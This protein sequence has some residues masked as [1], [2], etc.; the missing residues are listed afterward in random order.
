MNAY[1]FHTDL[2]DLAFLGTIFIGL[3]FALQLWFTKKINQAANRFLGLALTVIVLEMVH[4]RAIDIPIPLQF[5][6]ALGPLIYFYVLKITRPA[7]KFRRKDLL[8]FIPALAG[9]FV[10]SDPA[11]QLLT[12]ISVVSY[13]YYAHQLIERF[14]RRLKFI[15]GD[16]YRSELRWL[17]KL[18]KGFGLLWLMWIPYIIAWYFYY[19]GSGIQAY[20]CFYLAVAVMLIWIAAEALS[21]A[22]ITVT[23]PALPVTKLPPPA[24]LKQKA[25][26]LK[27]AVELN[28]LYQ[29]PELN[30]NSLAEKLGLSVHELSRIINTALKKN[31]HDFINEY[32][33]RDVARKI[34]DPAYDHI[35]LLG[36]AYDSGFNSK[37][38]FHRIFR[39]MTGKSPSEYKTELRKEGPSYK[40]EPGSR[41]APLVLRHETIPKWSHEKSNRNFMLKSYLTIARRNLSRNKASSLINIGG[42][43]VGIACSL[44]IML[45]VQ[46]EY[47]MDA[48]HPNEAR[49]YT[50]YERVYIGHK[51]SAGYGTA[52]LIADEMKKVVP[53]VQYATQFDWGTQNTFQVGEKIA[54]LDGHFA[55]A[56]YFKV[57][58]NKLLQGN[59]QT[60]LN[61][62]SSI[63]ISRK[64]A[65]QFYGSPEAAIGKSIR[66]ENMKNFVVGAVFEDLPATSSEK[67]DYLVNWYEF[68]QENSWASDWD[69][70]GPRTFFMLRADANPAAVERKLVHFMD[71]YKKNQKAGVFSMTLGMQPYSEVYLHGN[72]T[73]DKLDGG[74]IEYVR[75]FSIIAV[76]I[77]LI[78][79]I[80]FMNLSTA[81][82]LNRAREIG[83]RK[84]VGAA[85][86]SLIKQFISESMLI[87][88]IAVGFSLLL[89]IVLLPVFNQ[90]TLKAISLPF[91]E[92]AFWLRLLGITLVTGLAS[93]S[94][95]ALFMSSFNP[96]KVLKGTLKVSPGATLFRKGLVVFQFFLST[97]LIIGT[98]VISRQ[99]NYIQTKNLGYNRENLIYLP[100]DGDLPKRYEI[101]KQ[102]ALQQPGIQSISRIDQKP[103]NIE[104]GTSGV[105]WTGKDPDNRTQFTEV[106]V[107]YDFVKSMKIKM[108]AGRDYSKDFPSD[109]VGY[110][111]NETALKVIGYKNPVGQPLTFWG[112][113]GTVIGIIKDFH[114]NSLHE[115]I[116]PMVL[117]F[118]EN[119]TY[120]TALIRT[121]PGKTK[122]ALTSLESI[123]KQLNPNFA[124]N[125]TFSD[126][127]YQKLY[128]NEEVTGKLSDAFSFLAIFIS[129]LG[130]LGLA[131]F[132]A[133]Q[134]VKEIGIRKVLGASVRSVFGLLSKEFL[135]LVVI[136]L[137]IAIPV[138][139]YVMH[140]WLESYQFSIPIQWWMFALSGVL[141]IIIAL[142]TISM[143]TIKAALVNPVKSLRSE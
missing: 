79:S 104:N 51:A 46:N 33:V 107:G 3:T 48:W 39:Q 20:Y 128:Q 24:A 122:D 60:A 63:S 125:Y 7:Y 131:M 54:K 18:L 136:A 127:E 86:T 111:L 27:K 42:L 22:E 108:M 115:Q 93:G 134:R 16:R 74:R 44:L 59:A 103:T 28:L 71:P 6:P 38:S 75:L 70:A 99:I 19:S 141:I 124:F 82:S 21:R 87:T 29:D 57:F 30:L 55:S 119:E 85:R 78:A 120:G 84:V 62:P 61:T 73:A 43:A 76:F 52:A 80:N 135:G 109:S 12:F 100:L 138:A 23:N 133:E 41:I 72:F 130:L 66:F 5:L 34:Q 92:P 45:W 77:L 40:L 26:W 142:A 126:D 88:V 69:N 105:I 25:G 123:W 95:P 35:T 36:I 132:T 67:F 94:Y 140:K 9:Q 118:G 64:M 14:Y 121:K 112:K 32:R 102:E 98:V 116:K 91:G 90:T 96:V 89:L 129:S 114:F 110:L 1:N 97:I 81:R 143:Q 101:L 11:L 47:S 83:V 137:I 65:V 68:M 15:G 117:R 17:H 49:I 113:K 53:E 8:H 13:L 50:L 4:I 2:Y 10:L 56:D 58:G 139:W 37:T 106:S 31:F